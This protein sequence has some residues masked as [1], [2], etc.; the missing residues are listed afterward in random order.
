MAHSRSWKTIAAGFISAMILLSPPAKAG[1]DASDIFNAAKNTVGAV[2]T[3]DSAC[4]DEASCALAIWLLAVLAGVATEG[5]QGMVNSFCADVRNTESKIDTGKQVAGAL[6]SA[7]GSALSPDQLKEVSDKLGSVTGAAKIADC[8]CDMQQ[9][10][11]ALMSDLGA[12]MTDFMCWLQEEIGLGACECTRPPPQIANCSSVDAEKCKALGYPHSLGDPACGAGNSIRNSNPDCKNYSYWTANQTTFSCTTGPEGTL[13]QALP[14]SGEGTG[15]AP[16]YYCFCPAG[17]IPAWPE[18]ANPD[19]SDKAYKFACNCPEGTHPGAKMPNGI[20]SCLCDNTNE[21]AQFNSLLG[22]CP[23]PACP[24]GQTRLGG[25]GDCVTPCADPK[26]GMAFDGSCCDPN[27]MTSCGKCCPVNMI[28]N[29]KTGACE[30]R[31]E[32]P[33]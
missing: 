16:V 15:C 3:C 8:A 22:I 5:G 21:P 14:P 11:G 17:M 4:K 13:V 31:P 24:P 1:C 33:K 12:C 19:S 27:Q 2:S 32:Q 23:P 29:A 25:D 20:S 26:Q 28:P 7:A 10:L 18:V 6:G 9:G 30:K